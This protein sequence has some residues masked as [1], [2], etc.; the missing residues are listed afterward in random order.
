MRDKN[1]V[2][3]AAPQVNCS[4]QCFL[5]HYEDE[6]TTFINPRIIEYSKHTDVHEEGCL[7]IPG[8]Y[9]DIERPY[10][11]VVETLNA[12]RE[13]ITIE[14]AGFFARIIQH[15]YDH[16]YGKLFID[17]LHARKKKRIIHAYEKLRAEER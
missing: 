3:I 2:G 8:V 11:I 9:A 16:L 13:N 17:Y 10:S 15:E 5:V 7:S 12:E 1:G 6:I 14:A 4:V